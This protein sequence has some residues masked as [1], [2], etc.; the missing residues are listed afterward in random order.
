MTKRM[1]V[2]VT[3]NRQPYTTKSSER[4]R[5]VK[6]GRDV[7]VRPFH[8]LLLLQRKRNRNSSRSKK[9]CLHILNLQVCRLG[10]NEC[11]KPSK[12]VPMVSIPISQ[13]DSLPFV[14]SSSPFSSFDSSL[15]LEENTLFTSLYLHIR[16]VLF[17]LVPLT[18][19]WSNHHCF[20]QSSSPVQPEQGSHSCSASLSN[21]FPAKSQLLLRVQVLQP[22]TLEV[23]P[24]FIGQEHITTRKMFT[25]Q[26]SVCLKGRK[27]DSGGSRQDF[28]SLMKFQWS[29]DKSLPSSINLPVL[30]E[31]TKTL[32]VECK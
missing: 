28:S 13:R 18:H 24:F 4:G 5:N 9:L 20:S 14:L 30:C 25:K 29:M 21:A 8:A 27:Q 23:P 2:T 19:F 3:V 15:F 11:S 12:K 26:H 16:S 32:S 10:K 31:T 1:N 17:F 7:K 6:S 22:F